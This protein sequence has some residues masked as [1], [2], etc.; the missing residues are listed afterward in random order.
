MLYKDL[1]VFFVLLLKE[2]LMI[3]S[4][5]FY[6]F[7][8]NV[9]P[10]FFSFPVYFQRYF[11]FL[12]G[13]RTGVFQHHVIKQ[14]MMLTVN[15][16]NFAQREMDINFTKKLSLSSIISLLSMFKRQSLPFWL[17]P[18]MWCT[19][20]GSVFNLILL[21]LLACHSKA[22]FSDPGQHLFTLQAHESIQD[23]QRL[24]TPDGNVSVISQVWFH[25][26]TQL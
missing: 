21:L 8:N 13:T 17:I 25:F 20:H 14:H 10:H 7:Y 18:S 2:L 15:F 12:F 4:L 23:W 1:L 6:N 5:T 3:T 22:V 24:R 9:Q 11:Y 26:P 19:L 16:S